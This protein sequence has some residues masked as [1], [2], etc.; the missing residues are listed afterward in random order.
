MAASAEVPGRTV[1]TPALQADV[2][3]WLGV[4]EMK[5]G[6][7]AEVTVLD[8]EPV[9]TNGKSFTERWTVD[10]RGTPVSYEVELIPTR[11]GGTDIQIKCE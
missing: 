11:E 8:T 5:D 4:C 10:R 7:S 3:H 2:R 9:S 1:A 6:A